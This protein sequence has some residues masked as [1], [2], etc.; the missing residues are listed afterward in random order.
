MYV[1]YG[2]ANVA[3]YNMKQVYILAKQTFHFALTVPV[4]L[5]LG[6]IGLFSFSLDKW[7]CKEMQCAFSVIVYFHEEY[8]CPEIL[9]NV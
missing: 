7:R 2:S 5:T 9:K 8:H 4:Q 6:S 1:I 3:I